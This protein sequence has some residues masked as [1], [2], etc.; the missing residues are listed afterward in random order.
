MAVS[1]TLLSAVFSDESPNYRYPSEP[2]PGD[3]VTI[4]MRV[5]KDSAKRVIMLFE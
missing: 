2:N 1:H 5:E 4:C 3:S